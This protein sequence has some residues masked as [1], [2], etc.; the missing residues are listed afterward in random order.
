MPSNDAMANRSAYLDVPLSVSFEMPLGVA[1]SNCT[2]TPKA[3]TEQGELVGASNYPRCRMSDRLR[4]IPGLRFAGAPCR[5]RA[6]RA[7]LGQDVVGR[8]LIMP[9][10]H[11]IRLAV[12]PSRKV[13]MI[14][15]PPATAASKSHHH[16]GFQR[17]SKDFGAVFSQQRLVV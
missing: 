15:T 2:G 9:A 8:P 12:R 16:L 5:S 3:V 10:I 6:A 4:R 17:R 11:S 1:L 13:L 7:H 14:G